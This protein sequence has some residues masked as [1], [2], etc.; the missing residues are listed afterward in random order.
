MQVLSQLSYSPNSGKDRD[1]LSLPNSHLRPVLADALHDRVT[2]V[3]D[4][5]LEDDHRNQ[6]LHVV[7][8]KIDDELHECAVTVLDHEHPDIVQGNHLP[9]PGCS[10][11]IAGGRRK[12]TLYKYA[13]VNIR[14]RYIEIMEAAPATHE[15]RAWFGNSKIVDADGN[16]LRVYHGTKSDI[17]AFDLKRAGA[18]DPGLI[19]KAFYFTPTPEQAGDFASNPLYGKGGQPNVVPAYL[20]VQRPLVIR[21]G[22]LPDGRSLSDLHPQGIT[23]QSSAAIRREIRRKYDGVVFLMDGEIVQVAVFQPTQ[24]KSAVGNSGSFAANDPHLA[25]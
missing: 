20:S 18:S 24:I 10:F 25:R 6:V 3:H 8:A 12:H 7:V 11:A 14:M 17:E 13:M 1:D 21:D 4:A 16:P 5:S 22:H 23:K 15:F 9:P 19:G 2:D